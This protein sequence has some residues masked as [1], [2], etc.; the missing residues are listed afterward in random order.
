MN[1]IKGFSN[2]NNKDIEYGYYW[3]LYGQQKFQEP[4]FVFTYQI[5]KFIVLLYPGSEKREQTLGG[6]GGQ[7]PPP[8]QKVNEGVPDDP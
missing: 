2:L 4:W 1:L 5:C 8:A 6:G 7:R 3:K